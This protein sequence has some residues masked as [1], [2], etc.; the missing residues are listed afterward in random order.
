MEDSKTKK[1]V[2]FRVG[3]EEFGI[4]IGQVL[5]IEKIQSIT[6]LPNMP[7]YVRGAIDLRGSV[8]P[9]ID[10]RKLLINSTSKDTKETRFI[11]IN[12][13]ERKIGFV[14]DAALDVLDI[15]LNKIQQV[16]I[17]VDKKDEFYNI[18]KINERLLILMDTNQL[19]TN[20]EIINSLNEIRNIA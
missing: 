18:A 5:S 16:T 17:N 20:K 19:L 4:N 15:P 11:V 10:L 14:V 7:S 13:D 9:I 8:V 2:I 1:V 3:N 6:K 12:K